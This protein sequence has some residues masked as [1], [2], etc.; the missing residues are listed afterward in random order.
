MKYCFIVFITALSLTALGQASGNVS[1]QN[2]T[3]PLDNVARAVITD[4]SITMSVKGLFN[5]KADGLVASFHLTQ[6]GETAR[7]TDSLMSWRINSFSRAIVKNVS[8]TLE[9]VTDVISF[10][11]KYNFNILNRLFSKTYQEIPDGFELKKNIMIR[12]S[13]PAD[14]DKILAA[15]ASAEIYDL[16]KVD[17]FLKNVK[18][19]YSTLRDECIS[20]LKERVKTY[21]SLGF[22]LDSFRK[23]VSDDFGTSLPPDR[24]GSYQAVARP[25]FE[26]VKVSTGGGKLRSSDIGLSRY[27]D[28]V[29]YND[30]DLVINPIVDRPM[31]QLTYEVVVKFFPPKDPSEKP[32]NLILITP[33]GQ[34]QKI[35]PGNLTGG[36]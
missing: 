8:D 4:E 11:P 6:L 32:N 30:F 18:G 1:Y 34:L 13:N 27:Y 15:A 25:S 14:L 31:V 7:A 28:P 19:N 10:V 21:E 17:Y 22:K 26:A 9:I 20:L 24:Y 23:T 5:V 29:S 3:G 16:V 33:A 12:Y 35:D 36:N 2:R